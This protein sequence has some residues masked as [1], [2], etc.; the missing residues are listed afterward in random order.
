MKNF[1]Q[2]TSKLLTA[3]GFGKL[4]ML[5]YIIYTSKCQLYSMKYTLDLRTPSFFSL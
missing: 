3:L 2:D 5:I 4:N 1:W